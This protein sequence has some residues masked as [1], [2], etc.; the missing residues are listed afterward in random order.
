MNLYEQ[1]IR[2]L[3]MKVRWRGV[4]TNVYT[5]AGVGKECNAVGY[6][7]TRCSLCL[8]DRHRMDVIL[9]VSGEVFRD[10]CM[11]HKIVILLE[12]GGI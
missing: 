4:D 8:G 1:T 6:D 2:T 5:I 9:D 12:G 7:P 3:G 11:S 10:V